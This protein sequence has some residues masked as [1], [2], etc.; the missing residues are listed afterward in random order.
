MSRRHP[1]ARTWSR[2]LM[3]GLSYP[4]KCAEETRTALTDEELEQAVEEIKRLEVR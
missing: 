2:T 3:R 1:N 4:Q